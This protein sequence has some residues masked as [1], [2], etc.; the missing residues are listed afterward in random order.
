M[1][2]LVVD[3]VIGAGLT[4]CATAAVVYLAEL[5]N[6]SDIQSNA[7]AVVSLVAGALVSVTWAKR[8]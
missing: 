7:I 4:L 5:L 3:L 6:P 2:N 1:T 8:R